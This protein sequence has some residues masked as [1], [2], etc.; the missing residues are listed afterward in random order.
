M[1]NA[2]VV[3]LSAV[4]TATVN[5]SAYDVGQ[6]VSASFVP[7]FGDVT[8]AG[9]IKLQ[10][11]NDNPGTQLNFTPS[12]WADVPNATS[13]VAAGVGPAIVVAN[14]CFRY[15]RAVYTRTSGGSS[16][17]TVTMNSLSI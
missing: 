16:T 12:N 5:G 10:A 15:I 3:I 4:D 2:Q 14:M 6:V 11:S 17:I 8:A 1:R 13:T 7:S 9:T